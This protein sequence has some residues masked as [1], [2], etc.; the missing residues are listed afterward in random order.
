MRRHRLAVLLASVATV[1]LA[2]SALAAGPK[3]LAFTDAKGDNVS[4]SAA[5]DVVGV[6][7]T[8]SGTGK[9]KAYKPKALV[10]TLQLAAPPSDD[11]TTIYQVN[12]N[13]PGCGDFY[14]SVVPGSPV[15]DPSFNFA[16]CGSEPDE[17]GST[18]TAF[19]AVPEVK[20]SSLVWTISMKGFPGKMAAG[21]TL[22]ALSA[23]TDFVEPVL[24]IV[25]PGAVTG[26]LYDS[27]ATDKSY[28]VG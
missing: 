14:V 19:D 26:P 13:L 25:G 17:T 9:G 8:T 28:T 21:T 2:G 16:D 12:A 1:S 11:G 24:G 22:G 20:G 18:G 5:Q 6:S 10:V 23:H 27:A 7:F 3:T 4:P 15:L